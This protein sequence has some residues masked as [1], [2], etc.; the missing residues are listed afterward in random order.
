MKK[1]LIT[2]ITMTMALPFTALHSNA[3]TKKNNPDKKEVMAL[4]KEIGESHYVEKMKVNDF[5]NLKFENE[6]G[7]DDYYHIYTGSLKKGGFHVIVYNNVPEYLGYYRVEFEPSDSE[8]GAILLDSGESDEDGNSLT[9]NLPIPAKG[10]AAKIRID[11]TP[12]AFV[13]N[14]KLE[15]KDSVAADGS[16]TK[17]ATGSAEMQA[18]GEEAEKFRTWTLTA[19]SGKAVTVEA[20]F[21]SFDKRKKMVTIRLAKNNAEKAF[22]AHMFSDEDKEYLKTVIE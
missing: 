9:F 7:E 12:V 14:P 8:E 18:A 19:P 21:V 16:N 4:L 17:L 5:C 10:P 2:L 1:S 11:G 20:M 3:G 15:A 6:A 22:A 13:K